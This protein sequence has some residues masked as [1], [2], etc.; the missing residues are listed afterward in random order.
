[1]LSISNPYIS[2]IVPIYNSEKYI[3][4]C[5]DSILNQSYKDIE[6]LLINDGS[7]D[8]SGRICDEYAR[9]DT[10]VKVIHKENGGVASA[11]NLGLG[12]ARGEWLTFVDS[13]DWIEPTMLEEV[14]QKAKIDNADLVFVDIRYSYPTCISVY[15][16]FRWRGKPQDALYDYLTKTRYCPG[17]GLI[18]RS[19]IEDNKYRFPENITIYEDF[20]LLVRLIF[21]SNIISQVEKPLYNYRMQDTSIVHST[22]HNRTLQNQTWAYNSILEY[23]KDNGVYDKY[24]PSLYGRILFDYQRMVLDPSMHSEF[25]EIYP[26]KKNYIWKSTTINLKL[27]IMMWCLTHHMSF[28][29]YL[30]CLARN[31]TKSYR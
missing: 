18:K 1:M 6:L 2:V 24:A 23:F 30:L 9:N 19:L 11:R 20:H 25:C 10:R 28:L 3:Y 22:S 7:T 8:A 13:D 17:W 5:V 15:Q 29:T 26:D 12:L 27:K 21:R 14:Y 16:T 4:Q 31:L